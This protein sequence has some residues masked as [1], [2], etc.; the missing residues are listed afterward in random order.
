MIPLPVGRGTI[1]EILA[2]QLAID[3]AQQKAT[4]TPEELT[5]IPQPGKTSITS[6]S[7]DSTSRVG[8]DGPITRAKDSCISRARNPSLSL[9]AQNRSG[10]S[11]EVRLSANLFGAECDQGSR[12]SQFSLHLRI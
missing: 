4:E 5:S 3:E 6:Q 11:I 7:P 12:D 9:N 2:Y 10:R 1:V 8:A